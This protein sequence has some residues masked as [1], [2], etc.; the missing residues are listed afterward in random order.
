MNVSEAIEQACAAV[1]IKPPRTYRQGTWAKT[2]TLAGKNGKGDGRVI[3]DPDRVT[4]W[5]WQTGEKETVWLKDQPS[6]AERRESSEQRQKDERERRERAAA[7]AMVAAK[8]IAA[9]ERGKHPYLAVKGFPE[10][11]ALVVP[12]ADIRTIAGRVDQYGRCIPADYL[13]PSGGH[14]AIVVPARI[15]NVVRSVQLIWEDGT[16]KFLFGAEMAAASH[17]LSMG[18]DTWLCEGF[19]TGLTLRLGLRGLNRADTVLC[20]FSASNIC[21]VAR[22]ITGRCFVCTDHDKP[23]P[24]Y[25]GIGTGEHYAV[26]SGKP[27]LMP[28]ILGQDLNDLHMAEGIFAVQRRIADFLRRAA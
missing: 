12:A 24:Q 4:S 2:D 21:T 9:A 16:K 11:I 7:A 26:A 28:P 22:S 1:G 15:G 17:R 20:C 18:R 23:L 6:P 10:E 27:Y 14:S 3:V 13:V 25:G 19:A 8:I 5:N